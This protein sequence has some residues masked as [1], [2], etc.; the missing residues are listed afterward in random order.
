MVNIAFL[1]CLLYSPALRTGMVY[2]FLLRLC[3]VMNGLCLSRM[4]Y[5]LVFRWVVYG[6][7]FRR[8]CV[9]YV[10]TSPATVSARIL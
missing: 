7:V 5:R 6:L 9:G 1:C 10:F 2:Q 4:V 8:D 3:V